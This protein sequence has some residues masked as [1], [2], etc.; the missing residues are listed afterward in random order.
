MK[1]PGKLLYL[2]SSID[3]GLPSIF[4]LPE[5]CSGHEFIPILS[6]SQFCGL[7]ENS[8]PVVPR[9]GLPLFLGSKSTVDG[10]SDNLLVSFVVVAEVP[11]MVKRNFLLNNIAGLDL[12]EVAPEAF[13]DK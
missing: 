3:F 10:I 1:G 13:R 5:N 12:G 2:G 7:K 8:R 4:S 6:A 11:R 9:E